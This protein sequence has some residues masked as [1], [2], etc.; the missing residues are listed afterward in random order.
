MAE[1]S[2]AKKIFG[3]LKSEI[4]MNLCANCYACMAVCPTGSIK[5]K[6]GRPV[7]KGRCSA[8]GLCYDQCPQLKSDGEIKRRIFGEMD[9]SVMGPYKKAYFG[10]A[11]SPEIM[12]VAQ[13]GG[14][15]TCLLAS[16]LDSGYVD[17]CVVMDNDSKW[18]P[19]PRVAISKEDLIE[20]AGRKYTPGPILAGARDARELYYLE[21]M[22]LVGTP[23]QVKALRCMASDKI[24]ARKITNYVKL[25][26][27][28]FCIK[29]LTYE[30]LFEALKDRFDISLS[31]VAKFDM[32]GE[33]F[34]VYQKGGPKLELAL[35]ELKQ[36][37][38]YPCNLCKDFTAE[39]SDISVG[40]TGSP[41][42][43]STVLTR[44]KVGEQAL[45]IGMRSG[46]CE[47]ELLEVDPGIEPV[48]KI[49]SQKKQR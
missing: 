25:I 36:F 30:G 26:V 21:E 48:K 40:G 27:G 3:H 46:A 17:G 32:N 33:R 20:C 19:I 28:L 23:C 8:C 14:I 11:N 18:R 44:T 38:F 9:P 37:S 13:N 7:L 35:N 24:E 10:R 34:I 29:L 42:G 41:E 12:T 4:H 22:A 5:L 6:G 2:K 39:L 16:L 45:E 47:A 49:S 43:Y 1:G 15:V 31:N